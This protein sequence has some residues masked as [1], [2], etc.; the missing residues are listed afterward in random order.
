M[1]FAWDPE[2]ARTNRAKH[3]V[4][5]AEAATSFADPLALLLD[6]AAHPERGILIGQSEATRLLFTV[7]VEI[8]EDL[9]RIISARRAT[10]HERRRYEEGS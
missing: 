3:G 1:R 4:S 6:D 9:I 8:Q 5:F 7:Y 10:S 2:K